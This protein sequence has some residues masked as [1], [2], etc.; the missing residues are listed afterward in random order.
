MCNIL[1]VSKNV[2]FPIEKQTT[3]SQVK[4][5]ITQLNRREQ[6]IYKTRRASGKHYSFSQP[7]GTMNNEQERICTYK[8]ECTATTQSIA[9]TPIKAENVRMEVLPVT[10][11]MLY[12]PFLRSPDENEP[13][14]PLLGLGESSP[15]PIPS[16]VRYMRQ[17]CAACNRDRALECEETSSPQFLYYTPVQPACAKR[18]LET[19]LF[20]FVTFERD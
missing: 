16:P 2:L 15:L 9:I 17:D 12:E 13:D 10:P 7:T 6:R 18:K 20:S 3:R 5:L 8:D 11:A 14:L 19:L 4:S 1:F